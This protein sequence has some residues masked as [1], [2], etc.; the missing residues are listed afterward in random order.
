MK[1]TLLNLTTI[2]DG[3]KVQ[4]VKEVRKKW[5]DEKTKPGKRIAFYEDTDGRIIVEPLD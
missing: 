1:K 5:G 3:W 4:L 2:Q